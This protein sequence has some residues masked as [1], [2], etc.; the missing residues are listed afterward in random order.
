MLLT[1]PNNRTWRRIGI[2]L[3]IPLVLSYYWYSQHMTPRGGTTVGL[4]YGALG[5]LVISFLL[6]HAVRK[7]WHRCVYGKTE[8][9][10]NAHI[11][12]GLLAMLLIYMHAG[13][14]FQ[15][16]SATVAAGLLSIVTVSGVIGAI[17]YSVMPRHLHEVEG[18]LAPQEVSDQM[19]KL[20][21]KV[22]KLAREKSQA[23]RSAC[24][25]FLEESTPAG[26][27]G[28]RI[29]F[30]RSNGEENAPA[31][32][33]LVEQLHAIPAGEQE[34]LKQVTVL[35]KQFREMHAQFRTRM[36]LKNLLESWL[37]LH[38]PFSVAMVLAI[39]LHLFAV[40]YY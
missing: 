28:W 38:V 5:L 31:R 30:G 3:A 23:F 33:R 7:R 20:A 18:D 25:L 6:C 40:A 29:T 22:Q 2:V 36:R 13:F 8:V 27:M 12:F 21:E 26:W 37:Y 34:E 35:A 15:D 1:T 24:Q 10:L 39:I 16:L 9:W 14:R 4:I 17:L 11:Y 19:N 32:S